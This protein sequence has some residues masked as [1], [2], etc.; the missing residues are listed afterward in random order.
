M[1]INPEKL[2]EEIELIIPEEGIGEKEER[3]EGGKESDLPEAAYSAHPRI[4]T[5]PEDASPAYGHPGAA[6]QTDRGR[7]R[8][9]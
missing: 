4:R 5:L 1:K 7:P 6:D 8:G 9:Q 2:E 3:K